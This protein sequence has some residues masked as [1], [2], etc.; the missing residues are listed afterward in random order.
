MRY[1]SAAGFFSAR[2]G[3]APVRAYVPRRAVPGRNVLGRILAT[4]LDLGAPHR[5]DNV[6]PGED[7]Q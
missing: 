1:P 6:K 3:R 4:Q 5:A 2:T 7:G